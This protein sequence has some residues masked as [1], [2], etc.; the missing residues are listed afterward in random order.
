M[1]NLDSVRVN[2]ERK[3]RKKE[4]NSLGHCPSSHF[5]YINE[6][7]DREGRARAKMG[8]RSDILNAKVEIAKRQACIL[9]I[10]RRLCECVYIW[11]RVK[12]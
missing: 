10:T 6:S 1:D 9:R 11:S 3:F 4:L 2:L 5:D 7:L 12:N 8:K